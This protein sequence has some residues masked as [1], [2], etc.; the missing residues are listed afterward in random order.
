MS[1]IDR[2]LPCGCNS[3]FPE[4]YEYAP[5]LTLEKRMKILSDERI[6]PMAGLNNNIYQ[7]QIEG[8][9]DSFVCLNNLS[10][11]MKIKIVQSANGA[12]FPENHALPAAAEGED[13]PGNFSVAPINNILCSM[14]DK[15]QVRVNDTDMSVDTCDHIAHKAMISTLLSYNRSNLQKLKTG[16]FSLEDGDKIGTVNLTAGDNNFNADLN[17]RVQLHANSA[18]IDYAGPLPLDICALDNHLAPKTDVT[19]TFF[20]NTP[21][22][23]LVGNF[24]QSAKIEIQEMYLQYRRITMASPHIEQIMIKA[25]VQRYLSPHTKMLQFSVPDNTRSWTL[26]LF[27]EGHML[28]KQFIVAFPNYTEGDD[29]SN[30]FAFHHHNIKK[31]GFKINNSSPLN[32][33]L[34]MDFNSKDISHAYFRLC[35]EMGKN[36]SSEEGHL[37]SRDNFMNNYTLFP[38]DLTMDKCNGRH[39]HGGRK[40]KLDLTLEFGEPTTDLSILVLAVFDQLMTVNTKT[41]QVGI[42]IF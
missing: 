7:F 1:S 5:K 14:W 35:S 37:I 12:D 32:S 16:G 11:H 13:P 23:T 40:A 2:F 18:T 24:Q 15:I 17:A 33:E 6:K 10:L 29:A 30:P 36:G 20:P 28:P 34:N 27:S 3:I 22:F 31:I 19:F 41:K 4:G 21:S 39:L 26:P 42:E 25:P 38:F 8:Q 9:D